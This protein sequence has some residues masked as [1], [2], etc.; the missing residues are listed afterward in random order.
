VV[1]ARWRLA[2]LPRLL[3]VDSRLSD[4]T[5]VRS[6]REFRHHAPSK[7]DSFDLITLIKLPDRFSSAHTALR[8]VEI[9]HIYYKS[10]QG[11][12]CLRQPRADSVQ[13]RERVSRDHE[14]LDSR[15][16][17]ANCNVRLLRSEL[18]T[19]LVLRKVCVNPLQP[20]IFKILSISKT[21]HLQEWN[22]EKVL[23]NKFVIL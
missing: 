6:R 4:R 16:F 9:E 10:S 11:V 1:L 18:L 22:F 19:E 21:K 2:D 15:W 20:S 17:K 3:A 8:A 5:V 13:S 14:V 7:L 12:H 23:S